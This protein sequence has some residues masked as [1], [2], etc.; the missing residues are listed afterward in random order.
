M[1]AIVWDE[2]ICVNSRLRQGSDR[3]RRGLCQS[4]TYIVPEYIQGNEPD[5]EEAAKMQIRKKWM[6]S[7]ASDRRTRDWCDR[8][9]L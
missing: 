9:D 2:R 7:G 1:F 6:R 3:K 4:G 8:E 5:R